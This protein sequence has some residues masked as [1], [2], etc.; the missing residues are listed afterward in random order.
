MLLSALA[1]IQLCSD[2]VQRYRQVD[3]Q[4]QREG[5]CMAFRVIKRIVCLERNSEATWSPAV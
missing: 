1:E 5:T 2:N 3:R 4:L